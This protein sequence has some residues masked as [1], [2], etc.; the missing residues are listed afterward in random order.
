[1]FK[2]FMCGIFPLAPSQVSV[3]YV[4]ISHVATQVRPS[5]VPQALQRGR[6]LW[7]GGQ[8]KLG[9][10]CC[11]QNRIGIERCGQNILG[12]RAPK[13]EQA[14][15][16]LQLLICP[17]MLCTKKIEGGERVSINPIL[18]NNPL[19]LHQMQG[20]HSMGSKNQHYNE[21]SKSDPEVAG[22]FTFLLLLR[23]RKLSR[24]D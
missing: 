2:I 21:I 17:K 3:S 15:G 9:A 16:P 11:A 1:M 19:Y 4:S 20:K 8:D 5:E 12:G 14:R 6:V 22:Y 18:G 23:T 7:L 24:R 10:E 13:L